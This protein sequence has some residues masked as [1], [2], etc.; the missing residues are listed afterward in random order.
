M[1]DAQTGLLPA[2]KW[3]VCYGLSRVNLFLLT[4]LFGVGA[5]TG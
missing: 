1:F 3:D 5:E 4:R 2:G